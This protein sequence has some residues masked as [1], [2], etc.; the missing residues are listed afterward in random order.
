M[1]LCRDVAF[2]LEPGCGYHP[3][4]CMDLTKER[5]A[6]GRGGQGRALGT[7]GQCCGR[8]LPVTALEISLE[9]LL[10]LPVFKRG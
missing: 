5:G 1:A 7:G 3:G 2:V 9:W 4:P 10:W 6:E 8:L